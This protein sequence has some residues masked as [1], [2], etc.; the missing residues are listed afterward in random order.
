MLEQAGEVV[1]SL[2]R[3]SRHEGAIARQ[4]CL[5]SSPKGVWSAAGRSVMNLLAVSVVRAVLIESLGY[6]GPARGAIAAGAPQKIFRCP[7]KR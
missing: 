4:V 5:R 2:P 3:R 6:L 7:R 1:A